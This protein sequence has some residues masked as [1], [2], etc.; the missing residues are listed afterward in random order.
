MVTPRDI[1]PGPEC[2][3]SFSSWSQAKTG[4]LWM[5]SKPEEY[6]M[7][8]EGFSVLSFSPKH[9]RPCHKK[10]SSMFF[11]SSLTLRMPMGWICARRAANVKVSLS[12][13]SPSLC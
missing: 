12:D 10:Y 3:E 9:E 1:G 5:N 2:L 13:S 8:A 11:C 7:K 4:N 6:M